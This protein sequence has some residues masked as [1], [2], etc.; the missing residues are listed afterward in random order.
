M[1][2]ETDKLLIRANAFEKLAL[3]SDRQS[4]LQAISQKEDDDTSND[5]MELAE[6]LTTKYEN[7]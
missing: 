3:Y 1:S 6:E 4:F 5:K 2:K 7:Q